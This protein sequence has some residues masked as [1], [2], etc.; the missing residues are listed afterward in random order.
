MKIT[1]AH[2]AWRKLKN[3]G[4]TDEQIWT[5]LEAMESVFVN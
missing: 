5:R 1:Q 2:N 4:L 3:E